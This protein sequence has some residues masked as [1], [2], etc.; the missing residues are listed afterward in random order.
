MRPRGQRKTQDP[1]AGC[2]L[3]RER[4]ICEFIPSLQLRT[5]LSLIIH[6]KEMRRT[7]NTGLLAAKALVN[8]EVVVRGE[9]G[10]ALDLQTVLDPRF[11]PVLFFPSEDAIDLNEDFIKQSEKPIQLLVPDGNWRQASKIHYR[12][13]EIKELPRVMIKTPNPEIQRL[14]KETIPEGMATLQAI[15][16]AMGVI[17]GAAI[18]REL[19]RLY[20]RKL[21]GTLKG[22]PSIT[23]ISETGGNK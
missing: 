16:E 12:H 18:K 5:K 8:S 14:R 4:C 23:R 15:A 10:Q 17:E 21:E 6:Y 9:V 19:L 11:R 1:C 2:F 22:R 3:H 13:R 7:T 20:H